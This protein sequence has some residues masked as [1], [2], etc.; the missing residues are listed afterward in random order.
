M[1]HDAVLNTPLDAEPSG[2]AIN[3]DLN[4]QDDLVESFHWTV[5]V[6]MADG[7]AKCR[8][9]QEWKIA[10][11][12][13]KMY[14]ISPTCS[15]SKRFPEDEVL[16]QERNLLQNWVFKAH[17]R[18]QQLLKKAVEDVRQRYPS[19]QKQDSPPYARLESIM[20]N[21]AHV[22]VSAENR[23]TVKMKKPEA[24]T[25]TDVLWNWLEE[26]NVATL[27]YPLRIRNPTFAPLSR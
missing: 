7:F 21:V 10:P 17:I 22:R 11:D 1:D 25:V 16:R 12:H 9:L 2:I 19:G 20:P 26:M 3:Q 13:G 8:Q 5:R 14:W 4:V 27:P 23:W 18:E 6:L 15:L 24:R